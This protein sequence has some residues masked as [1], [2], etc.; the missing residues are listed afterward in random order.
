M[1]YIYNWHLKSK[2]H[3][4]RAAFCEDDCNTWITTKTISSKTSKLVN[5]WLKDEV[6][7]NALKKFKCFDLSEFLYHGPLDKSM[8][9]R[10]LAFAVELYYFFVLFLFIYV[11]VFIGDRYFFPSFIF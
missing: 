2:G 9:D 11:F 6:Y 3:E 1:I 10:A 7:I 4:L 5:S 8:S